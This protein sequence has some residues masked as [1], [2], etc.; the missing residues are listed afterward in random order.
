MRA[1]ERRI[2]GGARA[3]LLALGALLA[4]GLIVLGPVA[5]ASAP[6][7]AIYLTAP[8]HAAVSVLNYTNAY[9]C[10]TEK[11]GT[12]AFF[13]PHTG[14][15]GVG[16]SASATYCKSAMVSYGEG[17][18]EMYAYFALSRHQGFITANFTYNYS[19]TLGLVAGTCKL[20]VSAWGYCDREASFT[21]A[22]ALGTYDLTSGAVYSSGG[23]AFVRTAY[24]D[25]SC[26]SFTNCTTNWANASGSYSANGSTSVYL[27]IHNLAKTDK[28][29]MFWMMWAESTA[30]ISCDNA[31]DVS[32]SASATFNMAKL[33]RGSVLTVLSV[34]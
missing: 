18:S 24:V 22:Y 26:Y 19:A 21:L 1:V 2:P 16:L 8:Y 27:T 30:Y 13:K 33:G 3:T 25:T 32:G 10:A 29:D 15:A 20:N 5:G 34:T 9:G 23:V 4:C 31:R 17:Q 7:S 11:I 12:A 6:A 28:Y 14:A